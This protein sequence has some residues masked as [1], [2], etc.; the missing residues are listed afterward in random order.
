MALLFVH[1]RKVSLCGFF[2]PLPLQRWKFLTMK[3]Y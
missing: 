1:A 2:V 3:G